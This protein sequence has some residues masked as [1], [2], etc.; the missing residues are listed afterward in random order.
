MVK[1]TQVMRVKEQTG[2]LAN[3]RRNTWKCDDL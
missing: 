1:R 2:M 3:G